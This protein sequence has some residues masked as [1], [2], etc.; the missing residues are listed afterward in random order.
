MPSNESIK[1]Y[2]V[3]DVLGE[4]GFAQVHRAQVKETSKDVAIKMV[5]FQ[6]LVAL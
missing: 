5:S 1:D 2:N 3:Y 4:G 6:L